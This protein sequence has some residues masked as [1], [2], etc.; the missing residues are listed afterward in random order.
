VLQAACHAHR[1]GQGAI[2][3]LEQ[4]IVPWEVG[5]GFDR[6]SGELPQVDL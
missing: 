1:L 5:P 2:E 4:G 3:T 6:A